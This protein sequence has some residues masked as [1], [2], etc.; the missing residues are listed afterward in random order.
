MSEVACEDHEEVGR[1]G[2]VTPPDDLPIRALACA[3]IFEMAKTYR[4]K[5]ESWKRDSIQFFRS[6]DYEWWAHVAGVNV[7]GEMILR[8]LEK[9]GGVVGSLDRFVPDWSGHGIKESE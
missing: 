7:S 9:N 4:S 2:Q 6:E 8:A 1:L 5:H 3:V